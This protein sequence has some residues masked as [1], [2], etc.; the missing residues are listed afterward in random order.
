M[1]FRP[2]VTPQMSLEHPVNVVRTG[3]SGNA[4]G[5]GVGIGALV[6]RMSLER[7]CMGMLRA[8]GLGI[9]ALVS[10]M[11]LEREYVGARSGLRKM[12]TL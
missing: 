6:G 3:M 2:S 11:S 9:G 7:E 10:G 8:L 1:S 12:K 4:Q 5:V